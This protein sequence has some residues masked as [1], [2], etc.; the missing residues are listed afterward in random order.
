M[1]NIKKS[2]GARQKVVF[3]SVEATYPGGVVVDNT[4]ALARYTDKILPAVVNCFHFSVS[5]GYKTTKFSCS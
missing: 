2:T 4:D 1:N 5:L 3:D